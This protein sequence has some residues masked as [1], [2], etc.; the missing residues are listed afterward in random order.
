[1]PASPSTPDL[2][3]LN[4]ATRAALLSLARQAILSHW[5]PSLRLDS[6]AIDPPLAQAPLACFVTLHHG[7]ELR[8][9]IGCLESQGALVD[10]LIHFAR[11]AAFDDPRFPPL[12]RHEL[13]L[14]RLSLSLLGPLSPLP[15][16]QRSELEAALQPGEDGLWLTSPGHRATFLPAVWRELPDRHAFVSQLL[17][18]G[19]WPHGQWPTNLQ[20]WR[21]RA[22][23]I[24]DDLP[25]A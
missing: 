6:S 20:A 17:R 14:C 18:K 13:P 11:A 12:S 22:L 21:Y 5:S 8:G 9:C 1:M 4:A 23:E 15:A 3:Q 7:T 16:G 19:G 25:L 2:A 24:V 10:S